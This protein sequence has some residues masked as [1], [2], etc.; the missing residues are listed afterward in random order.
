MSLNSEVQCISGLHMQILINAMQNMSEQ[1]TKQFE[2][3][4]D[5]LEKHFEQLSTKL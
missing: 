3:L 5:K 1:L 4:G 2:Q